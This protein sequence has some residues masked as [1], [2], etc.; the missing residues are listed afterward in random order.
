MK[1]INQEIKYILMALGIIILGMLLYFSLPIIPNVGWVYLSSVGLVVSTLRL[2]HNIKSFRNHCAFASPMFFIGFT[3]SYT[4]K[5]NQL[6]ST[7]LRRLPL[8]KP[9]VL[10]RVSLFQYQ[11]IKSTYTKPSPL[12]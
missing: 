5:E 7:T 10:Y 1:I 11:K 6:L 8:R 3:Y 4:K 9:Y 2:W 12:I